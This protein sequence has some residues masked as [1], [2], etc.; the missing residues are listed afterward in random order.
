MAGPSVIQFSSGESANSLTSFAA[1]ASAN[2]I[3]VSV[4]T[5]PYGTLPISVSNVA[6]VPFIGP[7][8]Q[9]SKQVEYIGNNQSVSWWT[10]NTAAVS[11]NAGTI[12]ITANNNYGSL[13]WYAWELSNVG[14]VTP[15]I[16]SLDQLQ[17]S[18]SSNWNWSVPFELEANSIG[19]SVSVSNS[20]TSLS[21][22]S[23]IDTFWTRRL[24]AD[25][26]SAHVIATDRAVTSLT[27]SVA[28]TLTQTE[29][30]NGVSSIAVFYRT[31]WAVPTISTFDSPVRDSQSGRTLT[32]A[33]ADPLGASTGFVYIDDIS[34]TVT[35]YSNT[36]VTYTVVLSTMKFG[37]HSIK[38]KATD[39]HNSNTYPITVLPVS[40]WDY[41]NITVDSPVAPQTVQGLMA[42]YQIQ[43]GNITGAGTITIGLNGVQFNEDGS[44]VADSW[45]T[46]FDYKVHD[47][48][49][50]SSATTYTIG[51][52][53][54]IIGHNFKTISGFS[55]R[56]K[57]YQTVIKTFNSNTSVT[58]ATDFITV[59]TNPFTNG[60]YVQYYTVS[61]N[62]ALTG[63]TNAAFYYVVSAN[64]IGL[65]LST[66]EGGANVDITANTTATGADTA[67]H[68][69]SGVA[70]ST[71]VS[72]HVDGSN[73]FVR[74][75][76]VENVNPSNGFTLYSYTN[77]FVSGLVSNVELDSTTVTAKAIVKSVVNT[78]ILLAQRIT[79]D[80]NFQGGVDI[81]G[82]SSGATANVV[83]VIDDQDELYQIGLNADIEANVIT[84]NGTIINMN[85]VDS[86]FGYIN[87][88]TVNFVSEDGLRSGTVTLTVDGVGTGAGYYKSSKGFLSDDTYLHDGDFYQEYSYEI[89]SKVSVD[90]Y[91]DMFKK[92][93]HMAGTKFFG[94]V[95]LS[96]KDDTIAGLTV[97]SDGIEIDFNSQT[98]VN[99]GN[100]SIDIN[101]TQELK[102]INETYSVD[103]ANDFIYLA[104][105]TYSDGDLV[106]YYALDFDA[107]V[108]G[109]A[110]N[111]TYYVVNANSSGV[112]LSLTLG[113]DPVDLL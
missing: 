68:V 23:T 18:N 66:T 28:P 76:S 64:S 57:V 77:P 38:I 75:A 83:S 89:L 82:E 20:T 46:G 103:A 88:E 40:T 34:Q 3:V 42:G 14:L 30:E 65:K 16:K 27:S 73:G 94:S 6:L 98:S 15:F 9:M 86:G 104:N 97:V 5:T 51:A 47:G 99:S 78:S 24:D 90:H 108:A 8:S 48:S 26:G 96:E 67:G 17:Q 105:N 2:L 22:S 10:V 25:Q 63:L 60:D 56:E 71:V 41:L 61:G 95:V 31:N 85:V 111:T 35:A 45:V 50:W 87:G 113:G 21:N 92:V 49:S 33:N 54:A 74:V 107:A 39:N 59:T 55:P 12:T 112:K 106:L 69:L 4:V 43:W 44:F 58:D 91:A 101:I 109:L 70:N 110:N 32:T 93:M 7:N 81:T 29:E 37:L 13:R 100:E 84:A 72:I 1:N 11:A 19:L 102:A 62:T 80:N 79:F 52:A 36:S 53:P